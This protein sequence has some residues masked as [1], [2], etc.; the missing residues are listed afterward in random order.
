[1]KLN[2]ET[3]S[4]GSKVYSVVIL[5][6]VEINCNSHKDADKLYDFLS[7]YDGICSIEKY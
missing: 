7:K 4:D 1:L 5:N 6:L 2:E 3:L